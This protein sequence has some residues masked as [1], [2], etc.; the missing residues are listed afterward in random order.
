MEHFQRLASKTLRRLQKKLKRLRF[1]K[2]RQKNRLKLWNQSLI[3]IVAGLLIITFGAVNYY[4]V[5]TLSFSKVPPGVTNKLKN[6]DIPAEII[7]P[8]INIDLQIDPGQIEGGVWKTSE[9]NATFLTSS[10]VPGGGGNTVIYAHNKKV[11]FGNLPYLS[12]G[13]KIIIKTK[14]G[15]IY[16]YEVTEKYFVSP[17][18]VD[19]V[20]PT[21]HEMLTLY[22]CWGVFD[23]QRA[24]IRAVPKF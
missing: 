21:N 6:V 10:A 20:S 19:L 7:I 3:A 12:I 8:S 24:V 14:S 1:L 17:T 5:R 2:P 11:I 9:K 4:K 15:K 22:T 23:S 13:Q 18:R 16:N